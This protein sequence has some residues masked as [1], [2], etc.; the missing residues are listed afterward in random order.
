MQFKDYY[1][2]LG[3]EPE[4]DKKAIKTA[5]RRLARKYHPDV[6]K[7]HDAETRFKEVSEAY[8]VLSDDEKRSEYEQLRKYG[9]KG[10]SF[11]PPPV[12]KPSSGSNFNDS[13]FSDF[14]SSIFGGS[15]GQST[16]RG[17]SA[18]GATSSEDM[19]SRR[20][21]DVEIDMP[22][23]LEDTLKDES[24]TISFQLPHFDESGRQADIKKT[25]KV[26]IP[27]GVNHGEKIRLKGQGAPGFGNGSA[28]DLYIHI[29]LVPHPLFDVSGHD[30]TLILPIAP[31][32]AALG[33]K[34]TVPTL[35]TQINLTI[36]AGSQAGQ[37]LRVKSKG[38]AT[39]TGFGDLYVV[40]KIV[41]PKDIDES[42]K[43]LWQ[44]LASKSSFNPR[45]DLKN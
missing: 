17:R 2:I 33:A 40:L 34:V 18:R 5:Y 36:G 31:W 24:K 26:K 23:F 19:F 32:E 8:E 27:K 44:E 29:K 28:G 37:K 41:M 1:D 3:I 12:W 9:R 21:Q 11:T 4:A 25:L 38:L 7:E 22:I 20:G 6:S 16:H 45:T 13:D 39:K 15:S 30:L 43:S 14:F 42:S 10:E 35:T